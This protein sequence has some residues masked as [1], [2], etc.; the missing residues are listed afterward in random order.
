MNARNNLEPNIFGSKV[1]DP[2]SSLAIGNQARS[3]TNDAK[4]N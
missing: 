3:H 4:I 2:R 1:D